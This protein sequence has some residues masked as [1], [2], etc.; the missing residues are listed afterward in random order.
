[1][2]IAICLLACVLLQPSVAIADGTDTA[3]GWGMGAIGLQATE[4]RY[5]DHGV[6]RGLMAAYKVAGVSASTWSSMLGTQLFSMGGGEGGVQV[7]YLTHFAYGLRFWR[8]GQGA[9]VLRA[10]LALDAVGLPHGGSL[11]L[12]PLFDLGYQTVTQSGFLDVSVQTVVPVIPAA[13][14]DN[15]SHHAGEW[16]ASG[17]RLTAGLGS[18][19][20]DGSVSRTMYDGRLRTEFHADLCGATSLV[21]CARLHDYRYDDAHKPVTFLGLLV[22]FGG[23]GPPKRK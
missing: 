23:A 19:F 1:M 7:E 6:E 11:D 4:L 9:L 2:R 3:R 16:F 15:S 22:G 10:G 8:F 14:W 13:F 12:G 17:P 5:T 21:L 20:F 18:V